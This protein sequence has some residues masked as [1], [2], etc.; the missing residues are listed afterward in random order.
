MDMSEEKRKAGGEKQP[1][2]QTESQVS[3][4]LFLRRQPASLNPIRR[5]F[6]T[7]QRLIGPYVKNG[8]V[9]ADLGCGSGYTIRSLWLNWLVLKERSMQ[10]IWIKS[11]SKH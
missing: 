7:P 6:E 1:E 9:V 5:L 8:Q 3:G 10:L 2:D 11:V 4:S